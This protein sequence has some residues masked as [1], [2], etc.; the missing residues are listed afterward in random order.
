MSTKRR[1]RLPVS[2]TNAVL[3][4]AFGLAAGLAAAMGLWRQAILLAAVGATGFA[5]ARYAR[6]P[7]SGDV[8][9]VNAIEYRDERD[10]QIAQWGFAAVGVVALVAT[11]IQF[12]LA[13]VLADEPAALPTAQLLL[14]SFTWGVANTVAARRL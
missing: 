3:V 13:S 4:A 12:L 14:L 11:M 5:C 6:R 10:R 8:T 2:T 1:S 7:D 9:R